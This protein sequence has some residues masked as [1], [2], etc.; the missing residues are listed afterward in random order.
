VP[1]NGEQNQK[2]EIYRSQCCD[3]EIFISESSTFPHCPNHPRLPTIWQPLDRHR[4]RRTWR[5]R[6]L[7]KPLS[8]PIKKVN[9]QW[10]VLQV[11][12]RF[13]RVVA[14]H[15]RQRAIE[16]YLALRQTG[17]KANGTLSIEVPLFPGYVF[18]R[19]DQTSVSS[20]WDIPG[21]L[22]R[23][24]GNDGMDVLPE[25][26]ITDL[27]RILAAGLR[28]QPCPFIQQGRI[29]MVEDGP[30]SGVTGILEER[31]GKRVLAL[32]IPL[33]RRSIFIKIDDAHPISFRSGAVF[34]FGTGYMAS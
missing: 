5:D 17:R 13:E 10:H 15:L 21:V 11:R 22:A 24:R 34:P 19:C 25:Q 32:S 14:L 3:A 9:P 2:L 1:K 16:P 33:I 27:R 7:I 8:T 4:A 30:L 23:V 26:Q 20:L 28:V 12:P 29:V 31:A 18:C 6:S